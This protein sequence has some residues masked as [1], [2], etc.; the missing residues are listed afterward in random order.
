[1]SCRLFAFGKAVLTSISMLPGQRS[2]GT[3]VGRS[4]SLGQNPRD[5]VVRQSAGGNDGSRFR[6]L[7]NLTMQ[8]TMLT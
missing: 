5:V 3:V 8:R 2:L 6:M 4:A 7:T 1:M